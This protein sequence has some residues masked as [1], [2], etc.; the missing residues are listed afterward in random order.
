MGK[1]NKSS[2]PKAKAIAKKGPKPVEVPQKLLEI[3]C[4]YW[5][6][7]VN[8]AQSLLRKKGVVSVKQS[9]C[10]LKVYKN[11]TRAPMPARYSGFW[12][13]NCDP[14]R[15]CIFL[16]HHTWTTYDKLMSSAPHDLGKSQAVDDEQ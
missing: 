16:G 2:K 3:G 10:K 14:G 12:E 4:S 11:K 6:K 9:G 7:L 1:S 8:L 15:A 5:G 13:N